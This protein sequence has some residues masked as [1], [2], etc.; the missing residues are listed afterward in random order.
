MKRTLLRLA[1]LAGATVSA[2]D[3]G[4]Q[5]SKN[6]GF[7]LNGHV[8]AGALS[9][10]DDDDGWGPGP[11]LVAG[12]GFGQHWSV[13]FAADDSWLN[14]DDGAEIDDTRPVDLVDLG[15]RYSFGSD[16]SLIR[17]YVNVAFTGLI[18][19][20]D[21]PPGVNGLVNGRGEGDGFT[22]GAGVQWFVSRR[23]AVDAAVQGTWANLD[24]FYVNGDDELDADDF[25]FR[26]TDVTATRLQ[27]GVTW[28]P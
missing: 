24:Q 13:Y 14:Y 12:Y 21:A 4:A 9:K 15:V 8:N 11:G 16:S 20:Y 23:F 3:L 1:L 5:V 18:E 28:H 22:A 10:A 17:P 19:H 25:G 26:E 6:A 2:S 27:L 7:Y